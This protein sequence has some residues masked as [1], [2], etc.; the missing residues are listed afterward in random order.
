MTT[1]TITAFV[2]DPSDWNITCTVTPLAKLTETA[3][4]PISHSMSTNTAKKVAVRVTNTTESPYTIR[5][6]TKI[7]EFSLVTAKQSNLNRPADTAV[8]KMITEVDP[9][10]TT[11]LNDLLR[12]NRPEQ[13]NNEFW[14][15]APEKPGKNDDHTLIQTRILKKTTGINETEKLDPTDNPAT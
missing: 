8:R 1:K 4:L 7:A 6:H 12:T 13:Q 5:N 9:Y 3:S 10:I 15:P 11:Y 14:F 2:D